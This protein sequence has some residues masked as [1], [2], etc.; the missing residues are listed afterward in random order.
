M[1]Q[2]WSRRRFLRAG[3]AGGL[4]LLALPALAAARTRP[5]SRPV[6]ATPDGSNS[7]LFGGF[8]EPTGTES[9]YLNS[10]VDFE[11]EIG[12]HVTVYRTYRDW[13]QTIR[14]A[15]INQLLQRTPQPRLYISIHAFYQS[16]GRQTIQWAD[17]AAGKYDAQID[18]YAGE[19]LGIT[20]SNPVF[21]CFHHEMENELGKCGT[22]ADF[23]RAYWYFRNRIE[24]V[25]N[26]PNLTWVVTYMGNTVRG[27]HGGP[28]IWWPSTSPY[29]NIGPD[30][31]FGIDLYNRNLCHYKGWRTFQW[32]AQPAWQYATSLG[33]PMFIG[34]CGCVEGDACG[35]QLP[36]GTAKA[37][38]FSDAATYMKQTALAGEF[39]P[40]E[41]FCYSNVDG[42]GDG[43]YRV[44]TT[45]E[46]L[47]SF[48]LLANDPFFV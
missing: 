9:S 29:P 3:G 23:Q 26:V 15:S 1:E 39:T 13:G 45:P 22:A 36:P 31:L 24:I 8:S 14:N 10:L 48:T 28:G 17:I 32:L 16:K 27:Q 12:R 33:R 41:A 46:A 19:L 2:R 4:G 6:A 43:S 5:R 40:L 38:W 18:S 25:H 47:Q 42:Y 7:T 34:E 44:D 35:G 20:P 11:N 37:Q 30:Q 21:M